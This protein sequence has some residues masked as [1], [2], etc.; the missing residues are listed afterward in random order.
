MSDDD[1]KII[2]FGDPN[3]RKASKQAKDEFDKRQAGRRMS[4]G[5]RE[6]MTDEPFTPPEL[7][8][9]SKPRKGRP[10]VP[11]KYDIPLT[12]MEEKYVD[13]MMLTKTEEEA[14]EMAGVKKSN[15]R[16]F[17]RRVRSKPNVMDALRKKVVEHQAR[18]PTREFLQKQLLEMIVN[19]MSS[20]DTKHKAIRTVSEM[21]GFLQNKD[22]GGNFNLNFTVVAPDGTPLPGF[23][24]PALPTVA[25]N[26][27]E[28]D[29]E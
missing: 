27:D 20:P 12:N 24:A 10:V 13:C 9:L 5:K 11:Q 28:S 3:K 26:E 14:A 16:D 2:P 1:D 25:K 4:P 18:K 7:E 17:V 21:Q 19:P 6:N 22:A 23:T 8:S 15:I 29:D